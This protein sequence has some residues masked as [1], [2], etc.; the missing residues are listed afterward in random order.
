MKESGLDQ[1]RVNEQD[2]AT[3]FADFDA[4]WRRLGELRKEVLRMN[5]RLCSKNW[6]LKFL[7]R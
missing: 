6:G 1:Q 5:A 2:V 4:V 3:A 7:R